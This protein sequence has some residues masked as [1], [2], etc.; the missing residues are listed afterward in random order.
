[1]AFGKDKEGLSVGIEMKSPLDC[2]CGIQCVVGD[3]KCPAFE[4]CP[5]NRDLT[6]TMLTR[7]FNCCR[8][9]LK[10]NNLKHRTC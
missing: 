6:K 1:M 7:Y 2:S 9:A 4:V 3:R 5:V 10:Y 8:R